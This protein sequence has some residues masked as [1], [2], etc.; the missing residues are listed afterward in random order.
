MKATAGTLDGL[1]LIQ[2]EIHRDDR[3]LFLET[4][5][6]ERYR[7]V[8]V[9]DFVQ[10]NLVGSRRGVL[11]GLHYQQPAPQGKLVCAAHGTIVDVVV[12]IRVGS[13][14]FGHWSAVTLS[15]ETG[16]QVFV[17]AG[18]AHGYAVTSDYAI[19]YYKCTDYYSAPASRSI[20]WNDPALAIEWPV[21]EP[22]VN[23]RDR[24]SPRLADVPADELPR[25]ARRARHAEGAG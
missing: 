11:R 24:L 3:G 14:T 20:L 17:P 25:Y 12:D 10:D 8:G 16:L 9:P 19:V 18:F 7:D 13:P 5:S 23:D 15:S 2:P 6:A 22:I 21:A 1:L 4:W